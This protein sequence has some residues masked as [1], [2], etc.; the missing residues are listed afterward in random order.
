[1]KLEQQGGAAGVVGQ[2][3]DQG[4]AAQWSL[5]AKRQ[6]WSCTGR[7]SWGRSGMGAADG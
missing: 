1:V 4:V 3:T 5:S 2:I 6:A 7:R